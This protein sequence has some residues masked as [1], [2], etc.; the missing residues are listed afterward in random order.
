MAMTAGRVVVAMGLVT[1]LTSV[2]T[3]AAQPVCMTLKVHNDTNL[4]TDVL[5]TAKTVGDTTAG[6][7][8][9]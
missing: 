4:P 5:D 6:P 3:A 9:R 1:V 8:S 7:E 2:K